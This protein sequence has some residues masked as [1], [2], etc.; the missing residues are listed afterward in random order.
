M[1]DTL[2]GLIS[3]YSPSGNESTA[4]AWL[5]GRMHDL[6]YTQSF[7]DGAGNAVGVMGR[8]PR[9]VVLLGH[10]D[11][12]PGELPVRQQD[13][14]LY[15][16]GAVDAKGPLAAFVDAVAAL[17]EMEGW[18]FVVIGAVDEE[19]DSCGARFVAA[20]YRPDFA[21][22][23]EPNHWQRIALGYKGV[24]WAELAITRAQAHSAGRSQTACESAF[25]VWSSLMDYACRYNADKTRAFDQLLL[26]LRAIHSD[27]NHLRQR[28]ML[29]VDTR[30][31]P[32]ITPEQWYAQLHLLSGDAEITRQS[33][34]VPAW[35]CE[36]NTPVVRAFLAAIRAQGG[37]PAF[38]YKTGTADLN[39]VA[40]IWR[41]PALV[42]GPGDSA[43]DHTM[44]ECLSLEE[45]QL[46]VN[47][48]VMAL[49]YLADKTVN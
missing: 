28:A 36:K 29:Q 3:H 2:F 48:L 12:V 38:V 30:L 45:H 9:Q 31:P 23:G 10:I 14:I 8:G 26:T 1:S 39:T 34:A 20:Q 6:G 18:Q 5:T 49:Q 46:S 40:P 16:R 13:G 25:E 4:V 32:G 11:T 17:G 21:I 47:V 22:I 35:T 27:E 19:R 24:A 37:N 43:L 41:C 33:Y 15:G 44:D 7:V 42:Y